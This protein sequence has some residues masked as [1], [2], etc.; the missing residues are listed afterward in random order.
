MVPGVSGCGGS[1]AFSGGGNESEL[2]AVVVSGLG[3]C[4]SILELVHGVSVAVLPEK[5]V[6]GEFLRMGGGLQLS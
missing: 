5:M 2:V 6:I 4:G 1:E 3:V